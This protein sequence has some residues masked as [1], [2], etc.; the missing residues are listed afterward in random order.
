MKRV[1]Q[2]SFSDSLWGIKTAKRKPTT[3]KRRSVRAKPKRQTVKPS[4]KQ[5]M[6][7]SVLNGYVEAARVHQLP[8]PSVNL[9]NVI[10][11]YNK[12]TG[13]MALG[14]PGKPSAEVLAEIKSFGFRWRPRRKQWVAKWTVEREDLGKKFA[15]KIE[16]VD[17][18]PNWQRKAEYAAEQANKHM[19]ESNER[20]DRTWKSMQTIP[21]GQPILVGHYSEKS[22]RAHL[23]RI[24]KGFEIARREGAIAEKYG[25]RAK[26]YGRKARGES[27]GL[28]YRR[29][30]KLEAEERGWRRSIE[31]LESHAKFAKAKP[32]LAA[33]HGIKAD[34]QEIKRSQRY[35][36][37]TLERLKVEKEAYKASGGIVA[38]KIKLKKGDVVRTSMGV[39]TIQK[40]N[41]QTVTVIR[42]GSDWKL[43]LDK[44][45]IYGKA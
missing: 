31:E 17:I 44:S 42:Q 28:I 38:D 26:R 15:G 22:H 12:A 9:S 10:A 27:P 32:E 3:K 14:F 11:T 7:G 37:N 39:A 2:L 19:T 18:T 36:A 33:K 35:L 13:W 21:F 8:K 25:E 24:D 5:L 4:I 40:V 41:P 30:R 16:T 29:I 1:K 20:F 23:K 34:F 43:K 6:K 45:E